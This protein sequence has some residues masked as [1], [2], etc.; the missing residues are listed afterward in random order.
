MKIEITKNLNLNKKEIA[1]LDMHSFLNII[2]ILIGEL[3][4]IELEIDDYNILSPA[5][6]LC[7]EIKNSLGDVSQNIINSE[8]IEEMEMDILKNIDFTA[9]IYPEL[10]DLIDVQV[11][12]DNIKSIFKIL[13]V[14]VREILAR[15]NYP[16]KW[17]VHSIQ[18]IKNDFIDFF[19]AVEKNSKGK[20]KILYNSAEHGENDYFISLDIKSVDNDSIIMPSV[21]K[22][23]MR[24][25]MA[26][27]RKYTNI[28]GEIKANLDEDGQFLTFTV[29]DSGRGIPE[30]KI[31]RVVEFGYRAGNI[32]DKKTNGGGLGLTKAYF[33]TRQFNG[34][35]WIDSVLNEG[36]EITIKIPKN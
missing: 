13:K 29:K 8:K 17:E 20:Y 12:Q 3:Q 32:L 10:N 23:V 7:M 4:L 16:E 6:A 15:A 18:D 2:T 36:S 11:S 30:D 5:L 33:I 26:N 24:N 19:T 9:K 27:S 25:L 34:K 31:E 1:Q 21:F 35:M 14:R 28:G 22:D